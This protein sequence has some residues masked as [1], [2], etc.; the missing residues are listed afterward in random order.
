MLA[1]PQTPGCCITV[2]TA[3]GHHSKGA[4]SVLTLCLCL[5]D[6]LYCARGCA[7]GKQLRRTGKSQLGKKVPT[8]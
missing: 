4:V 8:P 1:K 7:G 3:C 5:E 2:T 6:D